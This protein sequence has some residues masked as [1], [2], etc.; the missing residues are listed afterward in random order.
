M[1]TQ[2]RTCVQISPDLQVELLALMQEGK[3]IEAIKRLR[4]TTGFPLLNVRRNPGISSGQECPVLQGLDE[5][6]QL[7]L[8]G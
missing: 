5:F 2:K 4:A 8:G 7:R 6:A 3:T 1:S